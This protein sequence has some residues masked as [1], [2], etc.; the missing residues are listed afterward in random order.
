MFIILFA[1]KMKQEYMIHWGM[2]K[3]ICLM[4][5]SERESQQRYGSK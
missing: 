4:K 3:M 1:M 2:E 5:A